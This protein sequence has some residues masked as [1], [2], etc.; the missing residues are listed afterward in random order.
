MTVKEPP[1]MKSEVIALMKQS[2]DA[3][4]VLGQAHIEL[5]DAARKYRLQQMNTAHDDNVKDAETIR[6]MHRLDDCLGLR[7]PIMRPEE[8][9]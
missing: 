4:F 2:S 8:S 1:L 3:V 6:L 9:R 5:L 7:S